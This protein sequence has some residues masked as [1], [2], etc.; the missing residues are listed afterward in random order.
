MIAIN[1]LPAVLPELITAQND[2]NS[3]AFA[4]VFSDN[5]LV[6]HCA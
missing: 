6:P 2:H 5:A 4:E 3:H 1:K